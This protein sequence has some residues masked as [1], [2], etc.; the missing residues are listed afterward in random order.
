MG[1]TPLPRA[2]PLP[3]PARVPVPGPASSAFLFP[4]GGP[5]QHHG[6]QYQLHAEGL[7]LCPPAD[8]T[9]ANATVGLDVTWASQ[10]YPSPHPQRHYTTLTASQKSENPLPHHPPHVRKSPSSASKSTSV[11]LLG[12][13]PT[14]QPPSKPSSPKWWW[15]VPSLP[16]CLLQPAHHTQTRIK[17]KSLLHPISHCC[18]KGPFQGPI[19]G[20]YLTLG[21][22]S[23]EETHILTEQK[24]VLGRTTPPNPSWRAAG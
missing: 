9:T 23:S 20:S 10:T 13:T 16:L 7:Q 24:T 12:M 19:V 18:R 1:Q 2:V 5:T 3:L 15:L 22:E 11:H 6:F 21:S 14:P 4:P 8:P 17:V